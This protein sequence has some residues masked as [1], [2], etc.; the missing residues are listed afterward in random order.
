VDVD[1][2]MWDHK[3][4]L[5]VFAVGNSGPTVGSVRFPSTAKNCVAVGATRRPTGQDVIAGYSSRGPASDTRYKPT[6]TAPGG[7]AGYSYINSADNNIGNPPSQTCAVVG[8]PFQGTSM[9]T[10]AVA[11]SALLVRQYYTEGWYPSGTELVD[12]AFT[13]SAALIKA[14]L[15]NSAA[16]MGTADIPNNNEGWGRVLLNDALYFEEDA[17]ELK[18]EDVTPGLTQGGSQ[19]FEFDVDSGSVPLEVTLVW[20]D[21]P[22][23]AGAAV[24]LQNNLDLTVTAPGGTAYKGNVFSAGQ[25]AAGGSYDA[26]NVEEVVRLASPAVGTYTV[27]VGGT[28]VP[29]GPQPFA[30]VMTGSFDE[31]P[32]QSGVD[33]SPA[34]ARTSPFR[35]DSISPNPFNPAATISYELFPVATGQARLTLRICSVDGRVVATLVDRVEDPGRYSVVWHGRADDGT[36]VASGIYFCKISYG[37]GEETQK[38]TLLK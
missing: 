11:G 7:E 12:D 16:D 31:W 2:F 20:T 5:A 29:H 28:T 17:R 15:T 4:F 13:P 36:P 14:T 10:P 35:L 38:L 18:V 27:Q 22:A 6:V 1:A 19:T 3:D 26:R 8:D 21:Y 24:T 9:A 37:G 25:S 34:P 23:T 30:L 33:D 32:V